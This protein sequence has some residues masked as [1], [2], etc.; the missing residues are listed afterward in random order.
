MIGNN[1]NFDYMSNDETDDTSMIEETSDMQISQNDD[2]KASTNPSSTANSQASSNQPGEQNRDF[3]NPRRSS[4][5]L[6]IISDIGN[7]LISIPRDDVRALQCTPEYN[8]FLKAFEG[9]GH[10]HRRTIIHNRAAQ[11]LMLSSLSTS[12]PT[13]SLRHSSK[14]DD[15]SNGSHDA[16]TAAENTS[17]NNSN[18]PKPSYSFLQHLA[19]DDVIL[20][21]FEFL[22][23]AAL[24]RT[25]R[26]CHRFRDLAV[27]SATQRTQDMENSRVLNS[28]MKMLRAKEQMEGVAPL[29]GPFVRV[30]ILSLPRRILV[31]QA[32]DEE[33]NGVYFCTGS[34]GNGFLFAKPRNVRLRSGR[35]KMLNCV[36]AKRYSNEVSFILH[37]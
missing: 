15:I 13:A 29:D 11:A 2:M 4:T 20:R 24:V 22:E 28:S 21:V 30:P 31:T 5:S 23:C 7:W 10:A 37:Y 14:Q 12:A 36:I 33:Y 17:I 25:S 34:N 32:G 9:L 1:N 8:K 27:Q 16:R 19:V 26:T 6:S 35:R 18:I 3:F